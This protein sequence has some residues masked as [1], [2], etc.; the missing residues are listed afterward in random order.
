MATGAITTL[1]IGSG[2]EL[3]SIL[4]QLK[5]ADK[6]QIN[7]KETKKVTLQKEVDAYN[8]I[9]AKLF[10]M[11][12]NALSL[13]LESDFLKNTVTVTDEEIAT[14]TVNDGISASS[15]S[16]DVTQKAR[17]NSWQTV[18]VESPSSLI[19]TEPE[20]GITSTEDSVTP[21]ADTMEILYGAADSQQSITIELVAGMSLDEV[22]EAIDTAVTNQDADGDARVTASVEENDGQYYI[23][24]SAASGGNS[25]DSQISITGFDYVKPDTTI[26]IS[27]ADDEDPLYLSIAP[28]TTYQQAADAI[29]AGTDNP[30]VTA[31]VI[32]TGEPDTPY[33]LTLTS[34]ATGE[35][36]RMSIQNLPMTEINGADG[37]SL[38]ALFSV[39]GISYQRQTND[40]ISDVVSGAT[41][42]LK[43]D[44]ETSVSIQQNTDTVKETILSLVSNFNELVKEVNGT[45]TSDDQTETLDTETENPLSESYTVKNMLYKLKALMST[46][47]DTASE[48]NSLADIGLEINR[49]GTLAFDEDLLDQ[50]LA[51][52]PDAVTALFIGD[53]DADITGLGDIINDGITAMVSSTGV[54]STEIDAAETR[55]AR[56]DEDILTATEQLDK[57]Y[58]TLTSD[59]VRLDTYI[60]QLNSES[61][62]MQSIIDSFNAT[63]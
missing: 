29:N 16:L 31:A 43:K 14:A 9:N 60:Q 18:G 17:F 35:N 20:T 42:N 5:E 53:T 15:F 48:Y 36:H 59:F 38:N 39:N 45:E 33:R 34:K 63:E 51:A 22:A 54:V 21:Q 23:R 57:R 58:D 52:N 28:G 62:Y 55:M 12:S 32:D 24:L 8:S 25:A 41:L 3:Q 47:L 10:A 49:D 37:D 11:K 27:R 6:T 40:A 4:D 1:G 7:V 46:S 50:A 19:Y 56:L 44:G 61:T 13:S 2:L 26:S 30:G